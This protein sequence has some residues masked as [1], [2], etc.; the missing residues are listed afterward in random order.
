MSKFK[1][2]GLS[3]EMYAYWLFY[4]SKQKGTTL[5]DIDTLF[6][7]NTAVGLNSNEH[8]DGLALP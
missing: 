4:R 7:K 1:W 5:V 2:E 6:L 8:K 3:T